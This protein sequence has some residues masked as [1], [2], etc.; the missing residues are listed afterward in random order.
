MKQRDID[1]LTFLGA[2]LLVKAEQRG[3]NKKWERLN[4]LVRKNKPNVYGNV[5]CPS[6][7]TRNEGGQWVCYMCGDSLV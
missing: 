5:Q 4:K 3:M 1:S 6:C 2:Y 7:Q